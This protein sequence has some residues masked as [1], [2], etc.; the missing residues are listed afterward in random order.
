MAPFV[1][2]IASE[3]DVIVKHMID[4]IIQMERKDAVQLKEIG[5]ESQ[6]TETT[7]PGGSFSKKKKKK[8]KPNLNIST[9]LDCGLSPS[10]HVKALYALHSLIINCP[11]SLSRN[12][13][14]ILVDAVTSEVVKIHGDHSFLNDKCLYNNAD[15]RRA[16]YLLLRSLVN[17]PYFP[18]ARPLQPTMK[19]F[20]YLVDWE[21]AENRSFCRESIQM[22][23][24]I[25]CPVI[26]PKVFDLEK[27]SIRFAS[28]FMLPSEMPSQSVTSTSKEH[29]VLTPAPPVKQIGIPEIAEKTIVVHEKRDIKT[30]AIEREADGTQKKTPDQSSEIVGN[31]DT[32]DDG[33]EFEE[34]TGEELHKLKEQNIPENMEEPDDIIDD[35]SMNV[36]D[37]PNSIKK[38]TDP[39][40]SCNGISVSS[41]PISWT[42]KHKP[43]KS[44][45]QK[46]DK[47]HLSGSPRGKN[48]SNGE[49]NEQASPYKSSMTE[50]EMNTLPANSH[51]I[52]CESTSSSIADSTA[53]EGCQTSDDSI[54]F[55]VSSDSDDGK[56]K[57]SPQD[58]AK[59]D[60]SGNKDAPLDDPNSTDDKTAT[61]TVTPYNL[62]QRCKIPRRMR[63]SDTE[64]SSDASLSPPPKTPRKVTT[65]HPPASTSTASNAGKGKVLIKLGKKSGNG[66]DS[67]ARSVA[68]TT[69]S[70]DVG[71][72][73]DILSKAKF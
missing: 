43:P 39:A 73:D 33:V 22:F 38:A 69:G 4:R 1:G 67:P 11:N 62:R 44:S 56:A 49:Q 60:L 28:S 2:L 7:T 6:S 65:L 16:L 47:T 23:N 15:N 40:P 61:K 18:D 21:T 5:K 58:S 66:R 25:I 27:Q 19:M 45:A 46:N 50:G 48:G 64:T 10:V 29:E 32:D 52:G 12:I 17:L 31:Y 13:Y 51:R 36:N 14:Q 72:L 57:E 68:S 26:A 20:H 35:E 55:M 9:P 63:N 42:K 53:R 54:I 3:V 71:N 24:L 37:S 8:H 41:T 30:P 34:P 59:C 70:S